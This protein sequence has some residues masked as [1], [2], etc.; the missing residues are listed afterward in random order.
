M[1]YL[2][3]IALLMGSQAFAFDTDSDDELVC[4]KLESNYS[5]NARA[6]SCVSKASI[7]KDKAELKLIKLQIRKLEVEIKM[8]EETGQL[9]KKEKSK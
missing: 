4:G 6:I 3:F 7:E 9:P 1:K 2:I 8:M 5:G